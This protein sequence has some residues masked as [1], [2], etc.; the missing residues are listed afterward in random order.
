[1]QAHPCESS[2]QPFSGW[3]L[4]L[5]LFSHR[6]DGVL[7]LVHSYSKLLPLVVS[8]LVR[9]DFVSIILCKDVNTIQLLMRSFGKSSFSKASTDNL[10]QKYK[11]LF[12]TVYSR[13]QICFEI[14]NLEY[15]ISVLEYAI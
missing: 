3:I 14:C 9:Y 4:S 11:F 1:L 10:V 7:A 12:W 13:I 5:S 2:Q 8:V 6:H 15:K